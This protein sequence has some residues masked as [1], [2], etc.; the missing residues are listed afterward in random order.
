LNNKT[1]TCGKITLF[2][3]SPITIFYELEITHGRRKRNVQMGTRLYIK[4]IIPQWQ[5]I[6]PINGGVMK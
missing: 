4:I 3:H 1:N 5:E 6:G 2:L